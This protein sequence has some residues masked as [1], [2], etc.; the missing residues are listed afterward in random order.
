[1]RAPGQLARPNTEGVHA[2]DRAS[3]PGGRPG[4]IATRGD[5]SRSH[6]RAG[7]RDTPFRRQRGLPLRLR[8]PVPVP[9]GP[10]RDRRSRGCESLPRATNWRP[11]LTTCCAPDDSSPSVW[12]SCFHASA[13]RW[14]PRSTATISPPF[15]V[16]G[17]GTGRTSSETTRRKISRCCTSSTL[18][19]RSSGS[20]LTCCASCCGDITG[21]SD[22]RASWMTA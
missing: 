16:H 9:L 11:F 5:A 1:M 20:R 10:G 7:F 12:T 4:R 14:S 13:I 17:C 18:R 2:E 21:A 3:H 6:P 15:T 8:I 22:C 19:P